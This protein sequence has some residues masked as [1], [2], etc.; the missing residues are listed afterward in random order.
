VSFSLLPKNYASLR[1]KDLTRGYNPW[2]H[3]YHISSS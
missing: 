3:S 1:L 2:L